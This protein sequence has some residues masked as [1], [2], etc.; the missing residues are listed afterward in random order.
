MDTSRETPNDS[1]DEEM[2]KYAV[3]CKCADG[4]PPAK[5]AMEKRADGFKCPSC[6]RLHPLEE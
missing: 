1:Q 5:E 3:E 4:K 6:G 2:T